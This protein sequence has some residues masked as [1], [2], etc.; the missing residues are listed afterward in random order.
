MNAATER[1]HLLSRR[2]AAHSH[3]HGARQDGVR[4]PAKASEGHGAVGGNLFR[5]DPLAV[6]DASTSNGATTV[7]GIDQSANLFVLFC[8]RAEYRVDLV[9]KD[10]RLPFIVSNLTEKVGRR[11]IDRLDCIRDQQFGNLERAGLA[12]GWFGRQEREPRRRVP[13]VH[14]VRVRDP[15]RVRDVRVLGRICNETAGELVYV[16][17]QLV[18]RL[19]V[20]RHAFRCRP[21]CRMP[22]MAICYVQKRELFILKRHR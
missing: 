11:D 14:Q 1:R 16:G 15:Q 13:R 5:L 6:N 18:V 4:E 7:A 19:I 20:A 12:R 8:L 3:D 22:I 17:Q 10:R 2:P 21:M 9:V